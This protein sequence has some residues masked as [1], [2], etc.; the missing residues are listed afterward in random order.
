MQIGTQPEHSL[1]VLTNVE[2]AVF[3]PEVVK[4]MEAFLVHNKPYVKKS[5]IIGL[6]GL[7]KIIYDGLIRITRRNLPLFNTIEKAKDWLV[8]N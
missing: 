2:G 7:Q 8:S 4:A 5:A 1:L 3:D 6:S